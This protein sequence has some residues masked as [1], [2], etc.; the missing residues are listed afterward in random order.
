MLVDEAAQ[1]LVDDYRK[2]AELNPKGIRR[3]VSALALL[4]P[5]APRDIIEREVK[6]NVTGASTHKQ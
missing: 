3:I 4:Y 6:R 5:A 1:H 2:I